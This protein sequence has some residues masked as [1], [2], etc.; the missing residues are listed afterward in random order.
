[1]T[2]IFLML[3]GLYLLCGVADKGFSGIGAGE[4]LA[5]VSAITLAGSLVFG[6]NAL[7]N[8]TPLAL[9]M[10]QTVATGIIK[11]ISV[12]QTVYRWQYWLISALPVR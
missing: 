6:K 7:E 4:I 12:M 1:M 11:L 8:T 2:I 9:T 3:V 10:V 5:L